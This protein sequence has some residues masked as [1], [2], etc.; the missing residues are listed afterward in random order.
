VPSALKTRSKR[1]GISRGSVTSSAAPEMEM[2]RTKQFI[3]LPA[4]SIAPDINTVL[5]GARLRPRIE[6]VQE[7]RI[8]IELA[9]GA[10]LGA[11]STPDQHRS[12]S[13]VT[14]RDHP[15][16]VLKAMMRT[17]FSY[18]PSSI[19][20]TGVERLAPATSVALHALPRRPKSSRTR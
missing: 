13:T 16:A 7:G 8:Y 6:A 10:F 12:I 19:S 4:N 3:V 20:R 9:N 15:S 18:C 17:G 1:S 2:L 11:G 14:S 5:R